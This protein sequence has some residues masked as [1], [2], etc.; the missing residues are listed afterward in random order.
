MVD[1]ID[2]QDVP[3]CC[4][5]SY[6]PFPPW[7]GRLN[8]S[9]ILP[10]DR[11]DYPRALLFPGSSSPPR[12]WPLAHCSL[13][14]RRRESSPYNGLHITRAQCLLP[15]PEQVCGQSNRSHPCGNG[16]PSG[17]SPCSNLSNCPSQL[18]SFARRGA[19]SSKKVRITGATASTVS[20]V[21]NT[22]RPFNPCSL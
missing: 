6:N 5:K 16:T 3:P 22:A 7:R 2:G 1:N 14:P 20:S 8:K 10:A 19:S 13:F 11:R 15:S 4:V 21:S 9:D 18:I 12:S 17:N